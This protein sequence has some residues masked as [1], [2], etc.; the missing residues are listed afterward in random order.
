MF[1]V[2]YT[3]GGY[4]R[5]LVLIAFFGMVLAYTTV[6]ILSAL[7]S[8]VLA[9]FLKILLFVV[10]VLALAAVVYAVVTCV[11]GKKE[12]PGS[13]ETPEKAVETENEDAL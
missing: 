2:F 4:L 10:I 5:E 12:T 3:R 13:E 11:K 1:T 6:E 7:F 9:F 8:S